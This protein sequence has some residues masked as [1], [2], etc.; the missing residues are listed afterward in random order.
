VKEVQQFLGVSAME[1]YLSRHRVA[2]RVQQEVKRLR[3]Q[4]R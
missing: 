3:E 4:L 2:R 1:V